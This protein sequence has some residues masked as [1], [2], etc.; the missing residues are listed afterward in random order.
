M[1]ILGIHDGHNATVALFRNNRV[2]FAL[3]EERLSR[4]KNQG[5]FPLLALECILS[6]AKLSLDDIDRVVFTSNNSHKVEWYEREALIERYRKACELDSEKTTTLRSFISTIARTIKNKIISAGNTCS[7][8]KEGRQHIRFRP[9][10][11]KGLSENKIKTRDHHLCHAA[12]AYYSQGDF[13]NK[14]LCLTNDGGG[15]GLCAT[16]SI[17]KE[18]KIECI[19][20]VDVR[21]SFAAL[22]ARATFLMGMTPLE[23]EYKIMGLAPYAYRE[24]AEPLAEKIMSY[25]EWKSEE[26]LGW[27]LKDK[28]SASYNFSSELKR[29]FYLERFDIIALAMQL[30][31]EKM[32]LRWVKN[33]IQSTK[34]GRLALAGG[35]F[36]NVK[37]NKKIL[38]LPEVESVFI[39]PSAG[40]ESTPFGACYYEAAESGLPL[41]SI[42]PLRTLYLGPCYQKQDVEEALRNFQFTNQVNIAEPSFLEDTIADLLCAGEIVAFYNEREEFGARALGARSILADPS[43]VTITRDLNKMIKNRDFWMPFAGTM[44]VEQAEKNLENI[45][46]HFAP[47]MMMTFDAKVN[48]DGFRAATH[49][50]DETIRP[51]VLKRSWNPK[52]YRIIELFEKKSGKKGGL[53]NT[54]FNLHGYPIVS[55]PRDA[56]E[57]FDKSGL[58]F[59][60]LDSF[61]ISKKTRQ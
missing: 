54:S 3:S 53:L 39:M 6:Q 34:I 37:L 60:A 44:T 41:D 33:C 1:N 28:F 5:G 50:Y 30:F 12:S 55:S 8:V 29:I 42:E 10:L 25:Y 22:Y 21:N 57:V 2:E 59:V 52:Y 19:A 32:A 35:L 16:V 40:D 11:E 24:K 47:Y 49:P 4:R 48:I 31:V 51:Q 36:M 61:L 7:R 27:Q 58:K 18:G 45:K 9:L 23:H 20:S 43:R 46:N 14:I 38:E 17:G 13:K 56:L 15:D 26:P